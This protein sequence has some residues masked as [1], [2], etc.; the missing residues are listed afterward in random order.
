MRRAPP[1]KEGDPAL[2]RILAVQQRLHALHEAMRVRLGEAEEANSETL[3]SIGRELR[4]DADEMTFDEKM[5]VRTNIFELRTRQKAMVPL[6]AQTAMLQELI[7]IMRVVADLDGQEAEDLKLLHLRK[8]V[9]LL[10]TIY[11]LRQ[12]LDFQAAQAEELRRIRMTLPG[13]F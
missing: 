2:A 13:W 5:E 9:L 4:E 12:I 7:E 6:L 3:E 1:R 11:L 10:I 8:F